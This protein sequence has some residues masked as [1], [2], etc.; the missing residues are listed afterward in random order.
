VVGA[1]AYFREFERM[2]RSP[3]GTFAFAARNRRPPKDPVNA[4]LS[5]AYALL[6]KEATVALAAEGLDPWWG[7]YHQ[8]RHGRPSLALDLMEEFRRPL[9]ADSV[10][11]SAVNN[12]MV[13][14]DDLVR[15]AGAFAMRTSARKALIRAFELRL[16]QLVTHP[17]FDYRCS[18]RQI[19]VLQARLLGKWLRG[20]IPIYTGMTTR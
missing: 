3:I 18:W 8:P 19:L 4:M 13:A 7:L 11:V 15:E 14:P 20:D 6:A 9:V 10:V 17:I 12:G 16:D 1:A 2:L 5:F